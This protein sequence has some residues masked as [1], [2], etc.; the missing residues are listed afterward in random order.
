M[1]FSRGLAALIITLLFQT[2]LFAEYLYKDEVIFNPKFTEQ[3]TKLGSEL[4]AKTG[5]TVNLLMIKEFPKGMN[6]DQYEESILPEFKK[7]T[8][9]L[10]FSEKNNKVDIVTNNPS[11]YK[12]FNK[13]QVLSMSA[14]FFQ[15]LVMATIYSHSL[16]DFKRTIF[17]SGG[18]I[19]PLLA[20]KCKT[21]AQYLGKYSA[22]MFNGYADV[23]DQIAKSKG[24]KLKDDVG[25]ANK[26]T[27][28]IVKSIF[29]LALLL[30]LVVYI[31]N[32]L[33]LRRL[34]NENK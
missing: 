10:I 6:I 23:V 18:T 17:N 12:Y 11:L 28:F 31:R 29:Y 2:Q 1:R 21:R 25:N 22:A 14:S 5:I 16:E 24:V 20:Q 3:I 4:F 32:K 13:D 9:L 7:D 26:D 30:I 19:I 15:S 34:K 33:Y 8:V 27:L